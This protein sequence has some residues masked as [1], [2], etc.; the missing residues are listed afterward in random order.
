MN[1]IQGSQPM[2]PTGI[3]GPNETVGIDCYQ[4]EEPEIPADPCVRNVQVICVGH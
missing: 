1:G 2:N 3:D 4:E